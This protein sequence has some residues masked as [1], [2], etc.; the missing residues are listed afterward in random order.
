MSNTPQ[1]YELESRPEILSLP[2]DME[3]ASSNARRRDTSQ[4]SDSEIVQRLNRTEDRKN[5]EAASHKVTP[6]EVHRE[7]ARHAESTVG[8]HLNAK[9]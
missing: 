4:H 8:H 2:R 5:L 7:A 3:I 1:S 9:A 6:A